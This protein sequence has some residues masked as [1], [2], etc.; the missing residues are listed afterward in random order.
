MNAHADKSQ[1]KN[2]KAAAPSTSQLQGGGEGV[3]QF[4]DNRPEN[5]SLHKL[6]G[7][8]DNTKKAT[9][10]KS[11]QN[12]ANQHSKTSMLAQLQARAN[13]KYFPNQVAQLAGFQRKDEKDISTATPSTFSQKAKDGGIESATNQ[14]A[15]AGDMNDLAGKSFG[16]IQGNWEFE[17]PKV[18]SEEENDDNVLS[19]F[20]L[21]EE[22]QNIAGAV[23]GSLVSVYDLVEKATAV[24]EDEKDVTKWIDLVLSAASAANTA[25]DICAKYK[26]V[27]EIPVLGS[28][29]EAAKLG[30]EIFRNSKAINLLKDTALAKKENNLT[31]KEKEDKKVL[32]RYM[33]KIKVD[34]A[35]STFDFILTLGQVAGD[36]FPP[37]GQFIGIAKGIKGL[38]EKGFRAWQAYKAEK[39]QQALARLNLDEEQLS[40]DNKEELKNL[41]EKMGQDGKISSLGQGSGTTVYSLVQLQIEYKS[42]E[43][44]ASQAT[45]DIDQKKSEATLAKTKL[46]ESIATYNDTLALSV[47]GRKKISE[48]DITEIAKFHEDTIKSIIIQ[49]NTEISLLNSFR[50]G[51]SFFSDKVLTDKDKILKTV[52][53][54]Q[55]PPNES[56]VQ[57]LSKGKDAGYFWEKTKAAMEKASKD[58]KHFTKEELG[59]RLEKILT[60]TYGMTKEQL[61]PIFGDFADVT[62]SRNTP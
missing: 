50:R 49:V 18:G 37:A 22:A 41:S 57:E 44:E 4:I 34:L 35:S 7:L 26:V 43:N 3:F 19:D 36:L 27:N 30:L 5:A 31:E 14:V 46:T 42:K 10:L 62:T 28:A 20:G 23:T 24:M 29:I 60:D 54:G 17:A 32:D 58:R 61:K 21:N 59:E 15:T 11:L 8:A 52:W 1:E 45:T 9:Q 55:Q 40:S 33:S 12:M 6:Q 47:P 16:K 2:T 51:M 13:N 25:V 48:N 38:F 39:E 53:K 56:L